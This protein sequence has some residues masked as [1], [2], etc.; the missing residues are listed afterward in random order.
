MP[1]PQG[2]KCGRLICDERLTQDGYYRTDK[3]DDRW[4]CAWCAKDLEARHGPIMARGKLP[5]PIS[6]EAPDASPEQ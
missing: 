4:Y 3:E 5:A 1:I 2:V 6:E